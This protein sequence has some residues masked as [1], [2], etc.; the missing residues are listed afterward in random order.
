MAT[1]ERYVFALLRG[2]VSALELGDEQQQQAIDQLSQY[3]KAWGIQVTGFLQQLTD[4]KR[5]EAELSPRTELEVER[6]AKPALRHG[7]TDVGEL[8][9]Q[10]LALLGGGE[11]EE[12]RTLGVALS[13]AL[14]DDPT[15]S[16]LIQRSAQGKT[17]GPGQTL[18]GRY[19]LGDRL[20]AGA[21]G[22][23]YRAVDTVRGGEVAIKVF[24]PSVASYAQARHKL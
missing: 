10:A 20:G 19:E 4:L 21:L 17:L 13:R 12:A 2:G 11:V 6:L 18:A 5:P 22:S 14:L 24:N 9:E 7:Q 16:L 23:V 1:W 15:L 8:T 3:R